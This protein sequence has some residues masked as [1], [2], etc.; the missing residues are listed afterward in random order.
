MILLIAGFRRVGASVS[1]G[2]RKARR[3]DINR[4]AHAYKQDR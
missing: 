1:A 2:A 4:A 3:D